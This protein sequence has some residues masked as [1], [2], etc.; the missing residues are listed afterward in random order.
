MPPLFRSIVR[1]HVA[2]L[3]EL[4][5]NPDFDPLETFPGDFTALHAAA[6]VGWGEAVPLL[7]AGRVPLD[8][9][10]A[11]DARQLDNGADLLEA[12]G[13]LDIGDLADFPGA[14]AVCCA[15][16]ACQPE[17]VSALLAASASPSVRDG[18]GLTPLGILS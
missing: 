10:L 3:R 4:I 11:Q 7:V 5:K 16:G 6:L 8:A 9:Q 13:D 2:G 15:I 12:C 1:H 14:T 17:A 18:A